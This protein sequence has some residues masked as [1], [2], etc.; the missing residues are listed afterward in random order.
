[1]GVRAEDI[2]REKVLDA[3][4]TTAAYYAYVAMFE[5]WLG[6]AVGNN[7]KIGAMVNINPTYGGT[8]A[9]D[10]DFFDKLNAL[11]AVLD[12]DYSRTRMYIN[13]GL[14]A[15]FNNYS[16][17]KNNVIWPTTEIFGRK[18]KDYQGIVIRELDNKILTNVLA[19]V[20]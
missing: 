18:V 3:D 1:L 6:M 15:Q 9:I 14:G 16:R 8:G 5:A 12:V 10:D 20:S 19:V 13:R 17:K 7:L 11:L 2:G 4:D